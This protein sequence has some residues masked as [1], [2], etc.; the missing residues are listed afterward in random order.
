MN[1]AK[2]Q[3]MDMYVDRI[4]WYI[5]YVDCLTRIIREFIENGDDNIHSTDLP[6]LTVLLEKFTYRLR[7]IIFNMASEWEFNIKN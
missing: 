4:V 2:E 1:V 6:N 3:K 5:T 7:Q